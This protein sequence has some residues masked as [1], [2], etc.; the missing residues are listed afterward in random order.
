LKI[1][2]CFGTRPEA[3]KMAS[4]VLECRN[5]NLE[6]VVCV[7]AQHRDMLDQVLEWFDIVPDYDLDLMEKGQNLNNLTAKIYSAIDPILENENPSIVL[8]QGDTTTALASAM[9]AFHR[10]IPV[11]HIE[12]GLRTY[13]FSAPFPE[14]MNRQIISKIA[15]YHFTPT[16]HASKNLISESFSLDNIIKT[17]NTV[18]DA[19]YWSNQKILNG[20]DN[21]FIQKWSDKLVTLKPWILVT[22]HRRENFGAG[23]KNLSDA[24]LELAQE[25]NCNIIWPVHPNPNVTLGI[26]KELKNHSR[27]HLID[28]ID[29][30]SM[31]WLM[32]QVDVIISDS[33]GIQEE[34]PTFD[35]P[36]LV[37]RE[38][39]ERPEGIEA[40]TSTLVGM[41]QDKIVQN[42]LFKLKNSKNDV[43]K[44]PFG[45]GLAAKRIWDFL[46]ENFG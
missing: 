33:G 42:V 7:T 1:L 35:V 44:N 36:V 11:G 26:G 37:T 29:Y 19:L 13:D 2:I 46:E 16:D 24:I 9:A 15:R 6:H 38:S 14:E 8:V 12:A 39:T 31:V 25:Y 43:V 22:A 32:Q 3:I 17:G 10:N 28:P 27:I 23:L 4:V 45:D 40:G 20:F 21:D 41:N 5:R 18:V 34:A 30:P